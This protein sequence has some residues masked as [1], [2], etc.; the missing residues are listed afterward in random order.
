MPKLLFVDTN[1]YLD[2]YRIRSDVKTPFLAHLEAIKDHLVIT[3]QVEMEFK[4]NRQGA[5]LEGMRELKAPARISVP[6]VLK[7]DKSSTALDKD[8]ANIKQRIQKLRAR[9]TKVFETPARYDKVYQVL[10]RLFAKKKDIDLYRKSKKRYEIR[11]LAQKRFM[12]GYPPRKKNDTSIGDAI[13]WEWLIHIAKEK[14]IDI[15]IVS[16]DG[17]YGATI[18][19]K[20]FVNDWLKQEFK[21]RIN[22]KRSVILC[23]RLSQAL[24][25]FNVPVTPEEEKEE[26][27]VI[28]LKSK[29][30]ATTKTSNIN[31]LCDESDTENNEVECGICGVPAERNS[32]TFRKPWGYICD[33]HFDL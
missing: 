15:W 13:N 19:E 32:M 18:G 11:E 2:F 24:K 21:E 17:D 6:S 9:Y 27:R 22:K 25:E 31:L 33:H 5:I 1:I 3:D 23:P 30:I 26:S 7:Q 4:K 8:I 16:R 28:N 14:N 29:I 10:Q 12:L 20:G